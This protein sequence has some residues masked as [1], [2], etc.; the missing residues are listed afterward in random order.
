[1]RTRTTGLGRLIGALHGHD[2]T[3]ERTKRRLFKP[4]DSGALQ[5]RRTWAGRPPPWASGAGTR[6]TSRWDS[7]DWRSGPARAGAGRW[8][9]HRCRKL[10]KRRRH[11][12]ICCTC[13][14]AL[15]QAAPD[16]L[17]PYSAHRHIGPSRHTSALLDPGRPR[18]TSP[19]AL[20]EPKKS[21]G[22]A[23]GGTG[24]YNKNALPGQTL[25]PQAAASGGD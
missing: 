10:G 18:S 6:T 22:H 13:R 1:M 3:P 14:A 2:E 12:A 17:R 8:R 25:A 9:V 20:S 19:W 15:R 4:T 16:Q 5:A 11:A 21:A 7:F 23:V 24:D